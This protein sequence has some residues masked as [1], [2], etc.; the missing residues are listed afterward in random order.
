VNSIDRKKNTL[1]IDRTFSYSY[2]EKRLLESGTEV[3][4]GHG[5]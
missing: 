4:I 1:Q 2:I 5:N 3:R